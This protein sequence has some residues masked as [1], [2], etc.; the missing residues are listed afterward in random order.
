MNAPKM[1]WCLLFGNGK[2]SRHIFTASKAKRLA[3]RYNRLFNTDRAY[4]VRF[5][6]V[7]P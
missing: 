7:T 2:Q 6:K 3:C 4:A 5:G 1:M